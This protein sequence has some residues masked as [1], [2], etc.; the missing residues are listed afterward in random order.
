MFHSIRFKMF[1]IALVGCVAMLD[2]VMHGYVVMYCFLEL[3]YKR[4]NKR[5]LCVSIT[6]ADAEI[7]ES[8]GKFRVLL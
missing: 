6:K 1:I 3:F 7:L 4:D 2:E 8:L 5:L